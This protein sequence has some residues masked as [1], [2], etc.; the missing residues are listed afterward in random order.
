MPLTI[1]Q[2]GLLNELTRQ[3]QS[4]HGLDVS[5]EGVKQLLAMWG[6]VHFGD[7]IRAGVVQQG[8]TWRCERALENLIKAIAETELPADQKATLFFNAML[9]P[10][11]P[12]S[13]PQREAV[14][15]AIAVHS[16]DDARGQ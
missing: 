15:S 5:A 3:I 14:L 10:K 9:N 16:R 7:I 12:L 2:E 8:K 4:I 11:Q 13:P 1:E 6:Y